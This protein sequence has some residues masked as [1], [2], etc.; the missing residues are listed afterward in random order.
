MQAYLFISWILFL[1]LS[2]I[3]AMR[4]G[5]DLMLKATFLVMF[6]TGLCLWL[7]SSGIVTGS[8]KII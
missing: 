5:V 6:I 1:F 4:C 7:E 8:I 3:W 2:C